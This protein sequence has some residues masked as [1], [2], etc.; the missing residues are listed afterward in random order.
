MLHIYGDRCGEM[1]LRF[2]S[3]PTLDAG[4]AIWP[5][6][7]AQMAAPRRFPPPWS[8]ERSDCLSWIVTQ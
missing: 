4:G 1:T 6:E 7:I 8:V 2:S 5:D 3:S